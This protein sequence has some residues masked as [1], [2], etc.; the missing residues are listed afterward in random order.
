MT[1][2]ETRKLTKKE[3]N[4]LD[5]IKDEQ[6]EIWEEINIREFGM[7]SGSTATKRLYNQVEKLMDR[8][9][10]LTGTWS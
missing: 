6:S 3:Q 1:T 5:R 4:E 9:F 10:E 8:E 7:T 2:N